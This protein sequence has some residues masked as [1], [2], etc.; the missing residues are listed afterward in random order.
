MLT[1]SNP[2]Y[3]SLHTLW[4]SFFP[5]LGKQLSA[6]CRSFLYI[7]SQFMKSWVYWLWWTRVIFS[8]YF[9]RFRYCLTLVNVLKSTNPTISKIHCRM[10]EGARGICSLPPETDHRK[11][12]SL[13]SPS[14]H[15]AQEQDIDWDTLVKRGSAT[16]D[17]EIAI[18]MGFLKEEPVCLRLPVGRKRNSSFSE[19]G[20]NP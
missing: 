15:T 18:T 12:S 8:F 10:L 13:M 4:P 1:K 6:P 9:D 19:G 7:A 5:L 2:E 17:N 11:K 14:K 3:I 16:K 20:E